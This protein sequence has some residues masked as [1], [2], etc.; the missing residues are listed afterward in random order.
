[1]HHTNQPHLLRLRYLGLLFIV[2]PLFSF[3]HASQCYV[4]EQLRSP[5]PSEKGKEGEQEP[6]IEQASIDDG[7]LGD[8]HCIAQEL[9]CD[10]PD[11]Q[12][13]GE[14]KG[15]DSRGRMG[16]RVTKRRMRMKW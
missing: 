7:D 6:G 15:V 13:E 8:A 9:L 2:H 5:A 3:S 12:G 10:T 16:R 11:S 14:D 1:M 4:E